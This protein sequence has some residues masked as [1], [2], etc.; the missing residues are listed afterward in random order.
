MNTSKLDSALQKLR[1]AINRIYDDL[2]AANMPDVAKL[3]EQG[4]HTYIMQEMDYGS[5][6][7]AD[8]R[9]DQYFE[10]VLEL[11]KA[12]DPKAENISF[13]ALQSAT[14]L[15]TLKALDILKK[16]PTVEFPKKVEAALAELRVN[17]AKPPT[18]WSVHLEVAGL[19][20][21][22]LPHTIGNTE[23]Y[24][25]D[26]N[27]LLDLRGPHNTAL[28]NTALGKTFAHVRV[29]AFD[30]EAASALAVQRLRKTIDVINLFASIL[31]DSAAQVY[32]P[33][34]AKAH[35]MQSIV[36]SDDRK[37]GTW[38]QRLRGPYMPLPLG[39][40]T[41]NRA[42][43]IGFPRASAILAK[44]TPNSLENRLLS[45]LQWAG[46]A[47]TADRKEEAFLLFIVALESL[48]VDNKEK[49]QL[50]YRFAIRGAHILATVF[51]VSKKKDIAKELKRL[52]DLRSAVVHSGSTEITDADRELARSFAWRAI[53][54]V[55]ATTPFMDM[56]SEDELDLW[57]EEQILGPDTTNH[58]KS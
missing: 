49:Q 11:H 55:L 33:W 41:G 9:V 12:V 54:G 45:A 52:Y 48:L 21:E 35:D 3:I 39:K 58:P 22:G 20:A 34:N 43:K 51:K 50:R 18:L 17:L 2:S 28:G 7:L 30:H 25:M 37:E 42:N 26:E 13:G 24:V 53:Y 44:P 40:M 1:S 5:L 46:R 29:R 36:L 4:A 14:Q 47:C 19:T 31:V 10:S 38:S 16:E 32:L 27:R 15:A 6:T 8:E 56:A 23:F 57:F